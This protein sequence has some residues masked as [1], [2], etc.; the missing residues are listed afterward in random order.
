M[1]SFTYGNR[2]DAEV[3]LVTHSAFFVWL[4][5]ENRVW[6]MLSLANVWTPAEALLFIQKTDQRWRD[7]L[8][9]I[10]IRAEDLPASEE[11]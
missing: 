1:I 10:G 5:R 8:A 2:T 4:T 9:D 6:K 7:L 11:G 3:R